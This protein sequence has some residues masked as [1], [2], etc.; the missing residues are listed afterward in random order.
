MENF[1]VV[2]PNE[3]SALVQGCFHGL[4]SFKTM[5]NFPVVYT[6][7]ILAQIQGCF[8]QITF[9]HNTLSITLKTTTLKR[10]TL[11]TIGTLRLLL[12]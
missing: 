2:Y 6:N 11:V 1:P 12:Q 3:I 5:E 7:E 4:R 8:P 9:L 10:T